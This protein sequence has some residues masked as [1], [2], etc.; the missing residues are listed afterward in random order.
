MRITFSQWLRRTA[1]GMLVVAGGGVPVACAQGHGGGHSGGHS[2]VHAG[3]AVHHG[4]TAHHSG[5]HY[6][7]GGVYMGGIGFGVGLGGYPYGGMGYGGIGMSTL[8]YGYRYGAPY[9]YSLPT[10]RYSVPGTQVPSYRYSAPSYSATSSRITSSVNSPRVWDGVSDLKPGMVL[11]D[12]AIV[13]SVSPSVPVEK[14]SAKPDGVTP[15]EV[16]SSDKTL[17]GPK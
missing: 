3:G 4:G 11:P 15:D 9:G 7:G 14:S 12:G 6:S 1:I 10:Y 17:T 2:G 8:P 16:I 5:H 13:V